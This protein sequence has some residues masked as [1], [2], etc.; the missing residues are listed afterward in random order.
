MKLIY[1]LAVIGLTTLSLWWTT[2]RAR[3]ILRESLRREIRPNEEISL[4]AWMDVP[5]EQLRTA[6]REL[7]QSPF[8]EALGFFKRLLGERERR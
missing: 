7:K 3:K 5:D 1:F 8:D 6:G 2:R 4:R